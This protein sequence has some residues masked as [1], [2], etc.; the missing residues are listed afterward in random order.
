M[1]HLFEI[2]NG[3]EGLSVQAD[4]CKPGA[5]AMSGV[6]YA[7]KETRKS[8]IQFFLLKTIHD[9]RPLTFRGDHAGLPQNTEV[10][11]QRGFRHVD[12]E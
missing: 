1:R 10:V 4:P 3:F 6:E 8:C 9:E 5:R 7:F 12:A 2:F 11:G